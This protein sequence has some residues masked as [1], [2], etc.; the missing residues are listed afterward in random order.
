M[1]KEWRASKVVK[2]AARELRH[3]LTPAERRLWSALRYKQIA[4]LRFR[5]QHPI[6]RF[7]VDFCC[8]E[9]RLIIEVD[10]A[11]HLYTGEYDC[12]RQE[13]LEAN[14][15]RV[16]RFTNTQVMANLNGVIE[17]IRQAHM[18]ITGLDEVAE[19]ESY[20]GP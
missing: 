20:Y 10:G 6:G 13:W 12:A 2:Q 14:G 5:R 7:I 4:G 11:V 15:Y 1:S 8:V 9:D 16:I 18:G 3:S 19:P 17:A